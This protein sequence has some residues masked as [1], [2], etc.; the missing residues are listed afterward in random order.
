MGPIQG[1]IFYVV[2]ILLAIVFSALAILMLMADPSESCSS[3]SVAGVIPG[4]ACITGVSILLWTASCLLPRLREWLAL[5]ALA[6]LILPMAQLHSTIC[7]HESYGNVPVW[8]AGALLFGFMG[9][10]PLFGNRAAVASLA[11][12]GLV[13]YMFFST[14]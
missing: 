14:C 4:F 5:L 10:S 11:G 6:I 8:A 9:Y 2:T 7:C 3:E 1:K 13:I 12:I